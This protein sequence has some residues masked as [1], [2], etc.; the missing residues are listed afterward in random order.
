MFTGLVDDIGV[1]EHV[2]RTA[3]GRRVRVACGYEDLAEGESVALNGACLT[4]ITHGPRWFEVAAIR[5]TLDRTTIGEWRE[6]AA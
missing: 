1:I 5:T 3:A 2:A 6:G 4:I